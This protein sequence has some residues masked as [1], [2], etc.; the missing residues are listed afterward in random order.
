V[1]TRRLPP[2]GDRFTP[3]SHIRVPKSNPLC[4]LSGIVHNFLAR[5]PAIHASYGTRIAY[6]SS[7]REVSIVDGS[8]SRRADTIP[9][10]IEPAF[11]ALGPFH[12]A[13]GMNN[14]VI[15][16]RCVDMAQIGEQEYL[17]KVRTRSNGGASRGATVCHA[18]A[19]EGMPKKGS[20]TRSEL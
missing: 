11:L 19:G 15:Y 14:H 17:G 12:L 10:A 1:D 9:V 7:L 18:R 6:L 5:L 4:G 3:C 16:Y 2:G 8:T 13:V 20:V